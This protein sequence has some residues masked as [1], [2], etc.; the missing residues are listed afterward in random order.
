MEVIVR[1]WPG[2]VIGIFDPGIEPGPCDINSG[3]APG[4]LFGVM[5]AFTLWGDLASESDAE[6]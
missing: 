3:V 4:I 1:V 6:G 2:T 5:I